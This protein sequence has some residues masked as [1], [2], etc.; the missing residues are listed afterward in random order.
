MRCAGQVDGSPKK[1][2][3]ILVRLPIKGEIVPVI[4][5][6]VKFNLVKFIRLY[7][8]SGSGPSN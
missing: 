8:E 2:S 3:E 6:P 5:F 4:L 1:I 7:K